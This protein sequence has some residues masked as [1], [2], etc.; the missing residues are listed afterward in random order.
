MLIEI[1][2]SIILLANN[3]ANI[4]SEIS[5]NNSTDFMDG[6]YWKGWRKLKRSVEMDVLCI[7]DQDQLRLVITLNHTSEVE[8]IYLVVNAPLT[9]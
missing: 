4:W 1:V 2:L 6:L 5:I 3:L 7:V 8:A 9:D